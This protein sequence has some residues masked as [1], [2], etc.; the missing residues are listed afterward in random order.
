M[1][2]QN[3]RTTTAGGVRPY[4]IQSSIGSFCVG[5]FLLESLELLML[6]MVLAWVVALVGLIGAFVA[7]K[8]FFEGKSPS[9]LMSLIVGINFIC[10]AV[11]CC[12]ITASVYLLSAYALWSRNKRAMAK[13][14][15]LP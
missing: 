14:T 8:R 13:R 6:S 2:E 3:Q 10:L 5:G 15:F 11:L 7:T 12:L 4:V 9:Y 1:S